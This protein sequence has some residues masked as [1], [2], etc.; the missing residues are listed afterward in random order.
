MFKLHPRL[1]RKKFHLRMV[2][3]CSAMPAVRR[4]DSLAD[5]TYSENS[6]P[7]Y[8]SDYCGGDGLYGY[9]QLSASASGT[10]GG[11]SST[12]STSSSSSTTVSPL[13]PGTATSASTCLPLSYF[14]PHP[15]CFAS[16]ISDVDEWSLNDFGI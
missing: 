7:G 14:P 1:E 3:V 11:T 4:M 12:T 13:R 8:P 10:K 5:G 2:R 15:Y 9:I 16:D 6:C